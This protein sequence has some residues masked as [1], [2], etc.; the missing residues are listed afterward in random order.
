LEEWRAKRNVDGRPLE[1]LPPNRDSSAQDAPKNHEK[2]GMFYFLAHRLG[3]LAF[4]ANGK[5]VPFDLSF[6]DDFA[7]N[8]RLPPNR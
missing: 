3:E 4:Y 5:A 7:L 2:V 6:D 8:M 1:I